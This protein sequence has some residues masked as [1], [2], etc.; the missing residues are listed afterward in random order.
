M[1]HSHTAQRREDLRLITG[2]G[3]YTADVNLP[4]Q[5]HAAFLRADRA[6]AQIVSID[7][8]PALAHPGV[9]AVLTGADALAAQY[10]QFPNLMAFTGRNGA[11]I[12]KPE[13]PVLATTAVRYVGETVAMV[14]AESALAAQDALDAIVVDYRDLGAV[15]TVEDALA[16]GAPQL[17]ANIPG[18]LCFEWETGDAAAV[19]QAFAKAAHI[20]RLKVITTRV[21]PSPMEP[22]GNL[23]SY[24]AASESYDIYTPSQGMVMLRKQISTLSGVPEAKL[25]VHT[26]DVGGSFGQ[27][28]GVYPEHGA[29]MMAAKRLG[30]PVKWV[31]SRAE[32]F[33]SDAHGRGLGIAGE[34]ALDRDGKF[35]AARYEFLC[36]MGAYLT[37][38]GSISHLRNPATLMTG[39]YKTPALYGSFKVVLTNTVPIAAYRGAGRP[40]IAYAVERLVDRAADELKIER[41][42]LRRR[43]FIPPDAFPYKTPTVGV[44]EP[45]DFAGC[46][47]QALKTADWQGFEARRAEAKQR[48]KL[49]GMGL[50]TI[51]EATGA[52]VFPKDQVAIEVDGEGKLTVYTVSLSSGQ[53]HETTF[54]SVVADTL[55]LPHEAVTLRECDPAHDLVGNHTGGSR[56]MAG[57]GSVC[58]VAADKLIEQAKPLAAEEL[59]LEP[60]QVDYAGG[61]FKSRDGEKSISFVQLA[62]KLAGRQPHPMNTLAEATVGSTWPNG[63]HIAEVEIDPDTG[64]TEIAS[65]V[66]VDD[67]GVVINHSIVEGQVHGGVTQGAGQMFQEEVVYDRGSGQLLTGSFMDYCMPRAGLVRDID[68]G[69]HPLPSKLNAIGAKG[70]GESGCTASLPALANAMTDAL[71]PAGVGHLDMPYTPSKV[72]HSIQAVKS[73]SRT[74]NG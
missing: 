29:L 68:V 9:V 34:L 41:S 54:T 52:G 24:D 56:S 38:T 51:I 50:S 27:R 60:S 11:Q 72:W 33:M 23:V 69:D 55:G 6:H 26:R 14:V 67:C 53:G 18:N 20:T 44:Y 31:G 48:G 74:Q 4:G 46:L 28:S 17:H 5:L 16:P 21:A 64:V 1:S 39:V 61:A 35:L 2:R 15:A 47:D 63:C 65:Y 10:T 19:E 7:T 3:R 73:K 8:A 36:D 25:R 58:K 42:E 62:K 40:D 70:V 43:N 37:P 13:R 59:E 45:S 66:A 32:G 49:R 71:R 30:R 12:L 22:R 57:V